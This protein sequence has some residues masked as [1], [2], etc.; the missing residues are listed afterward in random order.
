MNLS[1]KPIFLGSIIGN[2]YLIKKGSYFFL[3][4]TG[5]KSRRSVLEAELKKAGCYPGNLKL[6]I[7][8][9]GDFDHTGNCAYLRS[10]YNA[11]IIMHR[12]DSGMV[13]KGDMFH[14]RKKRNIIVRGLINFFLRIT[15]FKPDFIVDD[16]FNFSEYGLDARVLHLPGHTSGS[17]GILTGQ[18]DL[19][20]GDLLM[21]TGKPEI[22]S[23]IDDKQAAMDSMEKIK[24][25]EITTVY[26]G[27]GKPFLLSDLFDNK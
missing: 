7:L 11:K 2:C 5:R 18:G 22:S 14:N 26:P 1:I 3:V 24:K 8:T 27:H 4:D 12:D 15:R 9:H 16:D 13:E 25:L 21:N 19:I 10:R 23:I 17:I 20:C 6:I